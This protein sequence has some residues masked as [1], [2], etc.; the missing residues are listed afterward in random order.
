MPCR[1]TGFEN[2]ADLSEECRHTLPGWASGGQPAENGYLKRRGGGR[3]RDSQ[4]RAAGSCCGRVC[5][6]DGGSRSGLRIFAR[7]LEAH[8]E[9]QSRHR[10]QAVR[11]HPRDTGRQL[12]RHCPRLAE[13]GHG[14]W[15]Y[16]VQVT[17]VGGRKARYRPGRVPDP[18]GGGRRPAGAPRQPV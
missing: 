6:G 10:V 3:R 17:T 4:A 11:V 12:A 7:R 18:G 14:G 9:R 15:Y 8:H 2:R 13:S 1:S 16:A 5:A